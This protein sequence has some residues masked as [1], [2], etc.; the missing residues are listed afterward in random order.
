MLALVGESPVLSLTTPLPEVGRARSTLYQVSR[1]VQ[2]GSWGFN[3][4]GGL[5]LTPASDGRIQIPSA[6]YGVLR[7]DATDSQT[8]V[9]TRRGLEEDDTGFFLYDRKA[10]SY[11]FPSPLDVDITWFIPFEDLPEPAAQYIY[12]RAARRFQRIVLGSSEIEQL[13]QAD[14]GMALMTLNSYDT[15]HADYNILDEGSSLYIT[16]R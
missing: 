14:E 2:S 6:P 12:I 16:Q 3:F 13:S 5:E 11:V 7:V 10:H 15:A 4:E 1:E 8:D 9:V